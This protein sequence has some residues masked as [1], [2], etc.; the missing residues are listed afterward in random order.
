MDVGS[1]LGAVVTVAF[2][3]Y[4]IVDEVKTNNKRC[5]RLK[6]RIASLVT[7]VTFV[8]SLGGS[9]SDKYHEAL[10]QLLLCLKSAKAFILEFKKLKSF[11]KAWERDEIKSRFDD[12][13]LRLDRLVPT[14]CLGLQATMKQTID[15]TFEQT[16]K[17][18]ED[19][20]DE[21]TDW[22]KFEEMIAGMRDDQQK[23]R[24]ELH[25]GFEGMGDCLEYIVVKVNE[26]SDKL[27]SSRSAKE[28]GSI[29][30]NPTEELKVIETGD[31]KFK[32]K[33]GEGRFGKVYKAEYKSDIVAVKKFTLK[34]GLPND[35]MT[36]LRN[37]AEKM[38]RF[39][40]MNVIR[41]FGICIEKD[42]YLLIME[43][44]SE[45][46][47]R[48]VLDHHEKYNLD[49]K[50]RLRM[51]REGACGL[52]R[53]HNA[54]PP[55]LHRNIGSK[56]FL[57]NAD[58]H[59]KISDC[60]FALTKTSAARHHSSHKKSAITHIA[61]EHFI[62]LNKEY[63]ERSEVYGFGIVMWEIATLKRPYEGMS[64]K[65]IYAY[66]T[67]DEKVEPLN[68]DCPPEFASVIDRCRSFDSL[69][70]PLIAEVKDELD[71]ICS[72]YD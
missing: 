46:N 6:D 57:V 38:K 20:A 9:D 12:I 24:E 13:N 26:I 48:H 17:I 43:Y 8:R 14:L 69:M 33:I 66:L 40:S 47:L 5:K 68:S 44:M 42:N 35:V 64:D 52:F 72:K 71:V 4:K 56:K 62:N 51:A 53:I 21:R 27:D 50:I 61:P 59:V 1:V 63:T 15:E 30:A 11:W 39:D 36:K 16:R 67:K 23:I 41:L 70:R 37:E 31:L 65:E 7:P 45:T 54:D 2:E 18:Q 58:L 19:L 29:L 10:K 22:Q 60:G 28:R 3:I 55:M 25:E 34:P 49:W 32:E